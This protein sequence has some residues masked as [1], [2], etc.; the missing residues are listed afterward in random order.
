[1]PHERM[2][3]I[4]PLLKKR[5]KFSPI[6]GLIGMRQTGKTTIVAA[7]GGDYRTLDIRS[8]RTLAEND[9]LEYLRNR[10]APFAID[11]CQT[12]PDLF[13]AL[14][15]TVR[16][17]KNPGQFLVTGSVRFTSKKQIKES[18]TGRISTLEL[19]PFSI[20]ELHQL[21]IPALDI[22]TTA[23]QKPR[24]SETQWGHF[25]KAGGLPGIC[26]RRSAS[27]I[28]QAFENHLETL[29]DR[30]LRILTDSRLSYSVL[31]LILKELALQVGTN[32]NHEMICRNARVSKPTLKKIIFALETLF[33][34]RTIPK[35]GSVKH[36]S[37]FLEDVGLLNHLVGTELNPRLIELN[38]I[39]QQIRTPYHCS[40]ETH[41]SI[42][43]YE[44]RGGAYA[45]LAIEYGGRSTAIIIT[46]HSEP[47][48]SDLRS[49]QSFLKAFKDSRVIIAGHKLKHHQATSR[50]YYCPLLSLF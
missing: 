44:T 36:H 50:I 17:R 28:H 3:W 48:L 16:T 46:P 34:I 20:G 39:Y 2:R 35:K 18:L 49:A 47:Q 1:M 14:K 40:A 8:E 9:P 31:R 15:E 43:Q 12:V 5:L 26:F 7:L 24:V 4:L 25:L 19:L 21:K 27:L 22:H 33:I 10:K 32:L 37:L 6:V 29:L 41:F 38:A 23:K 45:P 11:E 30:D 13:P 42:F